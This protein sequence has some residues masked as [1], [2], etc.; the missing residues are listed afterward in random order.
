[1]DTPAKRKLWRG[2]GI[3]PRHAARPT[4]AATP[5]QFAALWASVEHAAFVESSAG[6]CHKAAS[7]ALTDY[8]R[9]DV[10]DQTSMHGRA[11]QLR[12]AE[13]GHVDRADRKLKAVTHRPDHQRAVERDHDEV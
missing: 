5:V 12:L 3:P 13:I 6:P 7:R 2:E 8:R 9:I 10:L 11:R 1:M 4:P